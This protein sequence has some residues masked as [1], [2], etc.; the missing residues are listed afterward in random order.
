MRNIII[1]Q[2]II[3]YNKNQQL[4]YLDHASYIKLKVQQKFKDKDNLSNDDPGQSDCA[5]TVLYTLFKHKVQQFKNKKHW[6]D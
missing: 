4:A 3:I 6:A 5:H 1:K 2:K